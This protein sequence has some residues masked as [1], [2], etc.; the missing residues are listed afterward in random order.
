MRPFHRLCL[1]SWVL[2]VVS[3]DSV[4]AQ[5]EIELDVQTLSSGNQI[6]LNVVGPEGDPIENANIHV[7]I[8]TDDKSFKNNQDYKTDAAGS[9][10][11]ELPK[12]I[13]IMRI[14]ARKKDH[15]PLFAHWWPEM[16]PEDPDIPS[17]Y[18]FNL[19]KGT[20]IGGQIVNEQGEPIKGVNVEVRRSNRLPPMARLSPGTW[21][22]YGDAALITDSDGRWKLSN[23]PGDS[24]TAVLL[25]LSHPQ[26]IDDANWGTYQQEQSIIMPLLRD[27]SAVI[28]MKKGHEVSG[29]VIDPDGNAVAGAVVIWGD[30]PYLETGSQEVVTNDAGHFQMPPLS[31]QTVALTVIAKGWAPL[32]RMIEI[33]PELQPIDCHLVKGN[34]LHM[35]IQDYEGNPIDGAYVGIRGWR[36]EKSLH[37]HKHPNVIDTKIPRRTDKQ[38][39]YIWSWAPE[40]EVIYSIGKKGYQAVDDYAATADGDIKVILLQPNLV[41]RGV[42]TDGVTGKPVESFRVDVKPAARRA[43]AI[44]AEKVQVS[45]SGTYEIE[46][47]P[48]HGAYVVR[49]DAEG[50]EKYASDELDQMFGSLELAIKL[51]PQKQ[52]P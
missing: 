3:A 40:D 27:Q 9:V 49:V 4:I 52:A 24:E 6:R 42:I 45:K 20:T 16:Q 25:K 14:W 11:A 36:G 51:Q 12:Q 17:E 39:D 18:Q 19:A 8:W 41:V 26:F 22:A 5:S 15:V 21:L 33:G 23:V 30:D 28:K 10:V 13:R 35:H 1:A 38:G 32:R 29:Q 44:D 7:S 31:P 46:V 34:P 48:Q 47:A 50:Y 37:N 43:V 2:L